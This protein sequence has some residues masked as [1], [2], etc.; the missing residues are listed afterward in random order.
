MKENQKRCTKCQRVKEKTE[1]GIRE[2][3]REGLSST[4]K[5]CNRKARK[6]YYEKNT[7][8]CLDRTRR[9]KEKKDRNEGG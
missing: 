7:D 4:C 9:W 3:G 6:S 2:K 8:A 5:V 1:F